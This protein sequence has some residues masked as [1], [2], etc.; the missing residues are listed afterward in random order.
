MKILSSGEVKKRKVNAGALNLVPFI[1][2]FSMII[3]FLIITSAM[4]QISSIQVNMGSDD[5]AEQ[6]IQQPQKEIKADLKISVFKD[7]IEMSDKGSVQRL[8]KS[9]SSD[10]FDWNEVDSFLEKAR[11]N[12]PEK[13]DIVIYSADATMYGNL[14]QAM[15]Y[16]LSHDFAELVVSGLEGAN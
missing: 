9:S 12:Y 14:V 13:K 4:D 15:D 1:D 6:V 10:E 16:S 8:E 3:I 5:A 7:R 11:V 2:L